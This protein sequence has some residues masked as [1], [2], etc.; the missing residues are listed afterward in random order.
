MDA[1]LEALLAPA[2][3]NG[4][5]VV[6]VVFIVGLL[7]WRGHLVPGPLHKEVVKHHK[8]ATEEACKRADR[9][10]AT[11]LQALSATEALAEPVETAVKV[12]TKFPVVGKEES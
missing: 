3:A 5:G 4:V 12:L 11:A 6:A 10:E 2:L 8:D 9:W 7:I 1:A